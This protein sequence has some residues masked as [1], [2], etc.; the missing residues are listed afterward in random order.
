MGD[1]ETFKR[2]IETHRKPTENTDRETDRKTRG[3]KGG[4]TFRSS[5]SR[6]ADMSGFTR[7]PLEAAIDQYHVPGRD[8]GATHV[9]HVRH[10]VAVQLIP[11][12]RRLVLAVRHRVER[13]QII[14]EHAVPEQAPGPHL[15]EEAAVQVVG[16]AGCV[17]V[18]CVWYF[19]CQKWDTI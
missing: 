18:C 2:H 15:D 11:L 17:F 4:E 7:R 16:F 13:D 1:S 14:A 3:K 9:A 8:A 12:A 6:V 5:I 19:V 10:I